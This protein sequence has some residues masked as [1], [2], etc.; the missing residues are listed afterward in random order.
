MKSNVIDCSS[1]DVLL[2]FPPPWDVFNSVHLGLPLL[3]GFLQENGFHAQ[4]I[5]LNVLI[6]DK[7]LSDNYLG[8][9]LHRIQASIK[10]KNNS[11]FEIEQKSALR[12]AHIL[13]GKVDKAKSLLRSQPNRKSRMPEMCT[14]IHAAYVISRA[15]TPTSW[16]IQTAEYRPKRLQ[17]EFTVENVLSA[18]H[19]VD[20][21]DFL[22]IEIERLLGS[23]L[24]QD[25][26]RH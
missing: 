16:N 2:L 11:D 23:P 15:F 25:S 4:C 3:A 6:Y 21:C 20:N 19:E 13:I 10:N 14:I 26:F 12:L 22:G 24:C 7:L 9:C 17:N 18:I 1:N 8:N 5:D